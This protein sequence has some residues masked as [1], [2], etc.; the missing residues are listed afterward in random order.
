MPV[1][2]DR[3]GNVADVVEQDVLVGLDDADI[4]IVQMLRYPIGGN[5]NQL[6]VIFADH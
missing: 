4:R 2:F 5:Q 3:A 1:E 6:I